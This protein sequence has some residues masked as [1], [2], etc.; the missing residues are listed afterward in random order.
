[1]KK[2]WWILLISIVVLVAAWVAVW[3][4]NGPSME[5]IEECNVQETCCKVPCPESMD[6][7]FMTMCPPLINDVVLTEIEPKNIGNV[8]Y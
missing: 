1:M 7:D 8:I 2:K 6:C 5:D 3:Y 4:F